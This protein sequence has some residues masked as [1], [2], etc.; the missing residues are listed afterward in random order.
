M[1]SIKHISESTYFI[2]REKIAHFKRYADKTIMLTQEIS[3]KEKYKKILKSTLSNFF[4]VGVLVTIS[5][6]LYW[7]YS[8]KGSVTVHYHTSYGKDA[9]LMVFATIICTL[10]LFIYTTFLTIKNLTNQDARDKYYKE[11][12]A[13]K[14]LICADCLEVNKLH[15]EEKFY[16]LQCGSKNIEILSD[17][18]ERH[19]DKKIYESTFDT[20]TEV[21]KRTKRKLPKLTIALPVSGKDAISLNGVFLYA[22]LLVLIGPALIAF[23]LIR[24]LFQ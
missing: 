9:E 11:I 7:E 12:I 15:V 17:F 13:A 24:Y 22:I 14:P 20:P 18:F 4:F 6:L 2:E 23:V 5:I 1:G 16:C 3:S 19:P 8:S 10:V 21:K